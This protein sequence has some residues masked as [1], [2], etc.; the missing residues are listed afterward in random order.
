MSLLPVG[1]DITACLLQRAVH[2]ATTRLYLLFEDSD[3][4][5]SKQLLCRIG[6]ALSVVAAERPCLDVVPLL[7]WAGWSNEKVAALPD[8]TTLLQHETPP[9]TSARLCEALQQARPANMSKLNIAQLHCTP[10]YG[11]QAGDLFERSLAPAQAADYNFEHVA[12]GGTF[13][14]LHAGHRML[15]AA[16]ALA[17]TLHVYIG[18]TS[19]QLL[20]KKQHRELLQSYDDRRSAAISYMQ[21]VRP[22]LHISGGALTDPKEPTAAATEEGMQALVVS[23]E[24]VPGAAAINQDRGRRGFAE[25]TIIVVDTMGSTRSGAGGDKLSSTLLRAHEFG[26]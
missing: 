14:R 22:G 26:S 10:Q 5:L 12:V 8:L 2:E 16:T 23:E 15:L 25:L 4:S 3:S 24:T 1:D 21:A 20:Q 7:H 11:Q 13:D 17:C 18:L 6:K 9:P 19:D